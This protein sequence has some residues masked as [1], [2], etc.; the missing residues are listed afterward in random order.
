MTV[1]EYMTNFLMLRR[2][3]GT[4][5]TYSR[6]ERLCSSIIDM[7]PSE[8]DKAIMIDRYIHRRKIDDIAERYAYS[9]RMIHYIIANALD[10]L[11]EI[12]KEM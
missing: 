5:K 3:V 9:D 10:Y 8:R 6:M 12:I 1:K 11:S 4:E 7:L 2:S